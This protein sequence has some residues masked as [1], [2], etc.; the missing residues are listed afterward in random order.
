LPVIKEATL[1]KCVDHPDK[2]GV[3]IAHC[4]KEHGCKYGDLDCPV[5][6]G[7]VEQKYPCLDGGYRLE[8]CPECAGSHRRGFIPIDCPDGHRWCAVMHMRACPTC[9][10]DG[11]KFR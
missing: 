6:L 7:E 10:K 1:T 11:G 9:N 2:Q 3:H 8:D 5:V 4:S